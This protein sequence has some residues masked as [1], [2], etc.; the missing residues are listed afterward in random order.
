M[1]HHLLSLSVIT[2]NICMYHCYIKLENLY[3]QRRDGDQTMTSQWWKL[4][5]W[6]QCYV[7]FLVDTSFCWNLITSLSKNTYKPE[8]RREEELFHFLFRLTPLLSK[9]KQIRSSNAL[10][11]WEQA[12][13]WLAGYNFTWLSLKTMPDRQFGKGSVCLCLDFRLDLT[14]KPASGS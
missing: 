10:H 8:K 4:S 2:I 6:C 13:A 12:A 5:I 7:R 11:V 9:S 14:L 1:S 3:Y